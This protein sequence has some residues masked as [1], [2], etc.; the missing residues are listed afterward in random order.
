[1]DKDNEFFAGA[2]KLLD[3]LSHEP[4]LRENGTGETSVGEVRRHCLSCPPRTGIATH[5]M[6]SVSLPLLGPYFSILLIPRISFGTDSMVRP[7]ALE[8]PTPR[9]VVAG[10]RIETESD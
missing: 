4:I 3:F 7:V 10:D 6:W 8:P 5:L 1:M 2:R 9:S